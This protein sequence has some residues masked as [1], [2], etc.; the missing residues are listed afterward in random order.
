[1]SEGWKRQGPRGVDPT[2][3]RKG[4]ARRGKTRRDETRLANLILRVPAVGHDF[5]DKHAELAR[6]G[7]DLWRQGAGTNDW[8][9]RR[10]AMSFE[11]PRLG[12][13][14]GANAQREVKG[15]KTTLTLTSQERGFIYKQS[16]SYS[17]QIKEKIAPLPQ[18][19]A[20]HGRGNENGEDRMS[21]DKGDTR[22]RDAQPRYEGWGGSCKANTGG[23]GPWA[24]ASS[25][26]GEI[27][28]DEYS[29]RQ[30]AGRDTAVHRLE[31]KKN[32][33]ASKQD[34]VTAGKRQA[35]I[36]DSIGRCHLTGRVWR[37]S[38]PR[39]HHVQA[40]TAGDV[41]ERVQDDIAAT[42]LHNLRHDSFGCHAVPPIHPE[43]I[44]RRSGAVGD[45]LRCGPTIAFPPFVR[46][47]DI[48]ALRRSAW[49]PTTT[50]MRM[51]LPPPRHSAKATRANP[52]MTATVMQWRGDNWDVGGG[53]GN[54][55][56][57]QQWGRRRGRWGRRVSAFLR[58]K[59]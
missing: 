35:S 22:R 15:E 34:T 40:K 52:I 16:C 10:G 30:T 8:R 32:H 55:T 49:Y 42:A 28:H 37:K 48:A 3:K 7:G 26:R 45:P 29:D 46:F 19:K 12:L 57:R 17:G 50:P 27:V 36:S 25:E 59:K 43:G 6:S 38:A 53:D 51:P 13:T 9:Q 23:G 18:A 2:R 31:P 39:S 54:V 41:A 20:R 21:K 47:P 1:M 33:S 24:M 5:R 58:I 56:A 4:E 14:S 44:P 11:C